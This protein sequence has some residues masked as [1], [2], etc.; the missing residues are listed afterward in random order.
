MPPVIRRRADR[1]GLGQSVFG[2]AL[3][4]AGLVLRHLG[5]LA[6]WPT[7]ALVAIG[8]VLIDGRAISG[9]VVAWRR[10]KL[11]DTGEQP[12]GGPPPG[13]GA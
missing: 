13:G 3:A 5:D 7:L 8:C 4:S 10:G 9:L 11:E 1:H 2:A 6:D 12:T